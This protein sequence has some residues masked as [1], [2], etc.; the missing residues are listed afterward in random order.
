[1]HASHPCSCFSLFVTTAVETF[2]HGY[3][4]GFDKPL[5][6]WTDSTIS[7]WWVLQ[8]AFWR[9]QPSQKPVIKHLIGHTA[10]IACL[11][12]LS[13]TFASGSADQVIN[14]FHS[15]LLY[16]IPMLCCAVTEQ[17]VSITCSKHFNVACRQ[18][19]FGTGTLANAKQNLTCPVPHCQSCCCLMTW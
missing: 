15:A 7:H 2:V 11:A 6:N 13:S 1:M 19:D 14:T 3:A 17:F 18:C 12:A 5:Y 4:G 16:A 9:I 8:Q 10:P